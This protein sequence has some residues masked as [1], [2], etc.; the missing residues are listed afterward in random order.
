MWIRVSALW[1]APFVIALVALPP[2]ALGKNTQIRKAR[3]LQDLSI[4]KTARNYGDLSTFL[5]ALESAGLLEEL[6]ADSLAVFAP[7][8][9]A[10]VD[11][12]IGFLFDPEWILHLQAL[13]L[14][15]LAE[16]VFLS[17]DL[18]RGD[19]IISLNQREPIH[20]TSMDPFTVNAAVVIRPDIAA[21]NGVIHVVDHV[22]FPK[23]TEVSIMDLAADTPDT[24]STL[25]ELLELANLTAV[26]DDDDEAF[27]G[28]ERVLA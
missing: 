20:V 18:S 5:R 3:Q 24:F 7:T 12:Q 1:F 27:T 25:V 10:F 2:L 26:L 8:D 4:V 17:E 13:L 28:R 23:F 15:H 14:Y 6:T 16:G 19:K 11:A 21:A 9:E 22:L